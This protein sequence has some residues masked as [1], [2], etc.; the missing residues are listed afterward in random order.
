MHLTPDLLRWLQDLPS[1]RALHALHE[2][3]ALLRKH[4]EPGWDERLLEASGRLDTAEKARQPDKAAEVMHHILGFF[5]GPDTLRQVVL[6]NSL[7]HQI[8]PEEE[9][10]VNARL[11]ALTMQLLLSALQTIARVEWRRLRK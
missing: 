6:S 7:G 11:G 5:A 1:R 9:E 2:I 10:A 8:K 4:R 3:G